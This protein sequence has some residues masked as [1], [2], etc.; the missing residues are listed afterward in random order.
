MRVGSA[1]RWIVPMLVTAALLAA[2]TGCAGGTGA[3]DSSLPAQPNPTATPTSP[4][5][6]AD[7]QRTSSPAPVGR[8][9]ATPPPPRPADAPVSVELP[10]VDITAEVLPVGAAEDG[11]MELPDDPNVVGWY[12][13]GPTAGDGTGSVVLAGHV[14]SRRYGLGAL[15]RLQNTEV[16][17]DVVVRTETGEIR[18]YAVVDVEYVPR[19]ELPI[20][21]VFRRDGAEQLLLITCAGDFDR[22][23]G[24][25]ENVIVTAEPK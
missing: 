24:Y 4:P 21:E 15:V 20:A 25:R 6:G 11:Q 18:E 14:D 13:F 12:R 2:L 9:V 19:A 7:E 8:S 22:D 10:S 16:G 23:R 1:V 5:T 17:D 3:G